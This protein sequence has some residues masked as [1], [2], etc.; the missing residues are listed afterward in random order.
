AARFVS[1]YLVQLTADSK[2]LDGPSGPEADFTD[3]HAWCE[4]YLPGA[5][6]V[7]LDPTSGLFASEGHI[8]LACTPEPSA[9]APISGATEKCEVTFSYSNTVTR[10]HEDPRVTKPY[11]E[12]QWQSIDALGN[13]LDQ[14]LNE[15]D[16]RLT[17]GGEPTFVSIDDMEAAQWNTDALGEH[18]LKLA[19]DLL[20]RLRDRFAPNGLLHYGQGKWYPGE[21]VPRWAL[22]CFWRK[23]GVPLWHNPDL[24]ARIDTQYGYTQT[25]AQAFAEA[26]AASAGI[27]KK[28]INAAYENAPF[29]IGQ[30]ENLP[31]GVD[32]YSAKLK[33]GL[34]RLRLAR[35]LRQGLDQPCGFVL[36]LAWDYQANT[37]YSTEWPLKSGRVV[38]IPGDSPM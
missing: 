2:S 26:L 38:L 8:P 13:K 22:G 25:D 15:Q 36:P 27:D 28:Y 6:W 23:D 14:Q 10:I 7:G 4:I 16:V 29:F 33:D 12:D 11:T 35:V 30:E 18:K 32:P 9:A 19:K 21:E 5:G 24:L 34:D 3:L 31:V 20:L 17:M 37:W 1:G